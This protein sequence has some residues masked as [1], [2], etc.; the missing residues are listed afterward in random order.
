MKFLDSRNRLI[1]IRSRRW[2]LGAILALF[3]ATGVFALVARHRG[4]TFEGEFLGLLS[5]VYGLLAIVAGYRLS[6]AQ[7]SHG[8]ELFKS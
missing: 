2:V 5:V 4:E 7:R 3:L 1:S 8:V 6:S